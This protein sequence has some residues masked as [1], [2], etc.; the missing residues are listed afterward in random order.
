MSHK[1]EVL[2]RGDI[3]LVS[4]DPKPNGVNEQKGV[5]PWLVVSDQELNATGPFIWAIPF[6]TTE[7]RHPLAPEWEQINNKT[8]TKGYLL[9]NQ[10]STLDV[11]HRSYKFLEHTN[12]P[13]L[14]D[15]IIQA[16]LGY[17]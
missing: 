2:G 6:T 3:I 7:Q 15:D 12:I 9:C 4:N 13:L 1:K 11:K 8:E 16:I 5:R 10:L 14:V 17:K